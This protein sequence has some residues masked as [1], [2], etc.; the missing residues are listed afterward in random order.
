MTT[1]GECVFCTGVCTW[2]HVLCHHGLLIGAKVTT[3][4]CTPILNFC[5]H[6]SDIPWSLMS[7]ETYYV[8]HLARVLTELPLVV[9]KTIDEYLRVYCDCGVNIFPDQLHNWNVS[10]WHDLISEQ[11]QNAGKMIVILINMMSCPLISNAWWIAK[12]KLGMTGQ[13]RS[14][15][16]SRRLEHHHIICIGL[17]KS[18]QPKDQNL[19]FHT[20][21]S[22]WMA[23]IPLDFNLSP[24]VTNTLSKP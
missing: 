20:T 19:I 7:R 4:F 18:D 14:G 22:V 8:I 17:F 3:R 13:V 16:V 5:G 23:N 10:E 6:L 2:K 24:F 1:R 21:N 9:V 15:S 12:F 11:S